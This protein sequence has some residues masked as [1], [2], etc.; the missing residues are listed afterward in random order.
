MKICSQCGHPATHKFY[1]ERRLAN[2]TLAKNIKPYKGRDL[3]KH[4]RYRY[5]CLSC[6]PLSKQKL[7]EIGF[8]VKHIELL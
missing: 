5:T 3:L 7:Q 4:N 2:G 1:A 6:F 8:I